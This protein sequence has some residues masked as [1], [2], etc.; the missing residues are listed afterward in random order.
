MT[1]VFKPCEAIERA[2]EKVA[3][4]VYVARTCTEAETCPRQDCWYKKV[5]VV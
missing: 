4:G 2:E 5:I 1:Q 3:D